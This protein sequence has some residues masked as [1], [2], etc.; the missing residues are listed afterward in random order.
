MALPHGSAPDDLAIRDQSWGRHFGLCLA[1]SW[2]DIEHI[3]CLFGVN[4]Q[5]LP[6][7]PAST[8]FHFLIYEL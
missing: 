2:Q 7:S 1:E 3:F 5:A 4:P 8:D 6:P